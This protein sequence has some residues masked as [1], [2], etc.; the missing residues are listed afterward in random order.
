MDTDPTTQPKHSTARLTAEALNEIIE[1]APSDRAS[2]TQIQAAFGPR[3]HEVKRL[4]GFY[5]RRGRY[6][7]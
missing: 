6:I 1:M 3:S 5:L 7:A 4:M 2:C